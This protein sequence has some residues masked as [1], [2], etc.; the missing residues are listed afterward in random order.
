MPS[1]ELGKT[2]FLQILAVQLSNQDPLEPTSDTEFIAQMAQ[3]S[4]LEQMQAMAMASE[5]ARAYS[6]IGKD[7]LAVVTDEKGAQQQIVGRVDSIMRKS[8]TEYVVMGQYLVPLKSVS[9]VYDSGMTNDALFAQAANYIGKYV[10]GE[11]PTSR[12]DANGNAVY[13]KISGEVEYVYKNE[14]DGLLY[15]KLKD[16]D[17]LK[18]MKVMINYITRVSAERI[19]A[20]ARP[21]EDGNAA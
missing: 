8:N 14:A 6:L 7:V 20:E 1:S 13:D 11:V 16:T 17:S 18:D 2:E 12:T 9:Q 5:S 19:N 3:F 4:S 21:E 15:V 10:E